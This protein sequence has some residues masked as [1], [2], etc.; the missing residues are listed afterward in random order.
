MQIEIHLSPSDD[1]VCPFNYHYALSAAF[2]QAIT[3]QSPDFGRALHDGDKFKSR[4]KLFVFSPFS[5]LPRPEVVK[6]GELTGLK[7]GG[8]VWLRFGSIVPEIVFTL[9][10]ALMNSKKICVCGKEFS[11][12]RVEMVPSPQFAASTVF[13]PFG[14]NG[15]ILC[16]YAKEQREFCRL[17]DDGGD[18]LPGCAELIAANLRHKLLRLGEIRSDIQANLLSIGNLTP[19]DVKQIP[20]GVEFLP[21]TPDRPYRSACFALKNLTVRAFRAPLRLTAPEAVQRIAFETGVG[22]A[23]SQG[24][25]LLTVGKQE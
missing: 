5:S 15:M 23:N 13:R 8:H 7:F 19:E 6:Q 9:G 22:S 18:G 11:V 20:I 2:Y 1:R 10:E 4:L 3:S 17:P 16:R 24:F 21:L 14:Q 12:D 25:G